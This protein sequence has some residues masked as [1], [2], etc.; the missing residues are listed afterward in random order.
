M[1]LRGYEIALPNYLHFYILPI[2]DDV[3]KSIIDLILYY[4][5][6]DKRG[7]KNHSFLK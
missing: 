3:Y 6:E 5:F 1:W 4:L 7:Q 2:Y